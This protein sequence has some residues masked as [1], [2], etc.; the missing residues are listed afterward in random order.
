[1]GPDMAGKS[2]RYA[3]QFT[4]FCEAHIILFVTSYADDTETTFI[5]PGETV[6]LLLHR[7]LVLVD[8]VVTDLKNPALKKVLENPPLYLADRISHRNVI[9]IEKQQGHKF[10]IIG[11]LAARPQTIWING[12]PY[13]YW[14]PLS[15]NSNFDV[16][17]KIH[18]LPVMVSH[19]PDT[20]DKMARFSRNNKTALITSAVFGAIGLPIA[21]PLLGFT[22]TGVAARSIAAGAQSAIYGGFT[23]G[24]FSVLQ[25]MGAAGVSAG[26]TEMLTA[27]G[28]ATGAGIGALIKEEIIHT[29]PISRRVQ[30]ETKIEINF[31]EFK[32]IESVVIVNGRDEEG[33]RKMIF[34]S[35]FGKSEKIY[36]Y[37]FEFSKS[38]NDF[39]VQVPQTSAENWREFFALDYDKAPPDF[40]LRGLQGSKAP[41]Y[42][43]LRVESQ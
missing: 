18:L 31:K 41:H 15:I 16:S 25:S 3:A 8:L 33:N 12:E 19:T 39:E 40:R 42:R 1:M 23:T 7:G 35:T 34:I 13:D 28:V 29:I 21:L 14:K 4:S 32:K 10:K 6:T 17:A 38:A 43:P 37:R 26:T 11:G 9:S 20:G 24:I 22:A 2:Q 27:F 36:R 5:A 30:N